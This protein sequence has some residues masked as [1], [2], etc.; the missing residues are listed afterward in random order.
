[1]IKDKKALE[2]STIVIVILILFT[3]TAL[4]WGTKTIVEKIPSTLDKEA[5]HASVIARSSALLRGT[6]YTPGLFPLRCKTEK[7]EISTSDEE[8]IKKEVA[9]AMFDC[10]W[11]LGEGKHDFFEPSGWIKTGGFEFSNCL[12]CSEIKF[13]GD[14]LEKSLNIADYMIKTPI[15]NQNITYMEYL[16]GGKT[17]LPATINIPLLNTN[18]DY[19]IIFMGIKGGNVKS[20]LIAG[21]VKGGVPGAMIGGIGGAAYGI[22]TCLPLGPWSAVCG[23]IGGIIGAA[24]VYAIG[25]GIGTIISTADLIQNSYI[26]SMYCNGET[27]GCFNMFLIQQSPE[28]VAKVC[29]NVESFT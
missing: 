10:W 1:M 4:A 7:I 29:R 15:P 21:N 2:I 27:G 23:V 18:Q 12:I 8:E 6:Q 22:Y 11:M 19:T 26:S 9:N 25:A 3:F 5:C 17:A 28:Q 13:K 14:A 24:K 20:A 16:S